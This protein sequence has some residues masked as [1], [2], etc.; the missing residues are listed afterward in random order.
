M[1]KLVQDH[2]F[3]NQYSSYMSNKPALSLHIHGKN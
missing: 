1:R 2:H 3:K